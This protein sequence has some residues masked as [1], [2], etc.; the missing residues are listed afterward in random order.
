MIEYVL[1][2]LAG[3]MYG[4]AGLT[5]QRRTVIHVNRALSENGIHPGSLWR[6]YVDLMLIVLWPVLIVMILFGVAHAALTEA[7]T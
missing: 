1:V 2:F 7:E 3:V 4:I 5:M 6:V